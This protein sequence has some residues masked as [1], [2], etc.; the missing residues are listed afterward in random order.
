MT[1]LAAAAAALALSICATWPALAAASGAQRV[2]GIVVSVLTAQGEAVVRHDAFGGMP[3]MTMVFRVPSKSVLAGLQP[4]DRIEAQTDLG[5]DEP[6]LDD[7][8]VVGGVPGGVARA[9][10]NVQALNVGDSMPQT[11]FFDQNGRGFDITDFRGDTVVLAFI[12]TRCRDPRMCPLVSSNFHL[13]QRK[14]AGLPVHLIEIT[15]DP[16]YD[17]PEVL[18]AYG[19]RFGADPAR[20][21]LGTGPID[22]VNDF[23]AQFG[24]AVFP[25]QQDGLIHSERTAIIDRDGRI[26]DLLDAAAWNA[27][28]VVADVR[29]LSQVPA[30]PIAWIDYELS[31]ASAAICGNNLA[32]YSGLLD[33]AM[34]T[35]IFSGACYIL[36]RAARKIFVENG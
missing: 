10:H 24:I 22:V 9:V 8:R 20:W 7:V 13:L 32:G 3:A 2:H 17:T 28:D 14:L 34:V 12:Y 1:K 23:A 26:T 35:L 21:T 36:Y 33:L 6:Q 4:G 25:D 30:N 11:E 15:L 27:D 19:Q 18:A 16:A 31:K 5:A 29:T